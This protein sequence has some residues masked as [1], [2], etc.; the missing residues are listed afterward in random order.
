MQL[1]GK[2]E[3]LLRSMIEME[4]PPV[5]CG[6]PPVDHW[7]DDLLCRSG[8]SQPLTSPAASHHHE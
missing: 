6:V 5:T 7:R 1:I 4:L 2:V 3:P 8:G